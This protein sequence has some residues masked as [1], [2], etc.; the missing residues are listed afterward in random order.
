M[1]SRFLAILCGIALGGVLTAAVWG[2]QHVMGAPNTESAFFWWHNTPN[3][4][5]SSAMAVA[6]GA[7]AGWL[8]SDRPLLV[9]CLVGAGTTVV[10]LL[11]MVAV[12]GNMPLSAWI[13]SL[14]VGSVGGAITQGAG[15][16]AGAYLRRA[17]P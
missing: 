14:L 15:A 16:M 9:G 6:P 7:L 10:G 8:A 2:L 11:M 12:W 3:V 17:A 13:P 4:L 1:H 5:L